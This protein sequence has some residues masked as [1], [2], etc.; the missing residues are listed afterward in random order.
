MKNHTVN[1][2]KDIFETDLQLLNNP[3]CTQ[4]DAILKKPIL[5]WIVGDNFLNSKEKILFVGKPHRGTPGEGFPS[6]IL[7]ST[8]PHLDWL[9]DC[10]WPYWSY[11]R[12]ILSKL[13]GVKDAWDYCS[14]TNIIKCTNVDVGG[15]GNPTTDQTTYKMAESCIKNLGVIFKEIEILKPNHIVF[16]TYQLYP[17]LLTDLPFAQTITELTS[18]HNKVA[19]GKKQL[20]WWTRTAQTKWNDNVK[21]LVTGHPERMKKDAFTDL[22]ADWINN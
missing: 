21:I 8:K 2:F 10:S 14:F 22:I 13:Y 20:G 17:D 18:Q 7:D 15:A 5:P 9:M 12:E 19:C 4:C 6:G 1:L 16:Y 3:I 11:T